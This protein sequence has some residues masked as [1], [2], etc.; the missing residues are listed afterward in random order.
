MWEVVICGEETFDT[1]RVFIA[2]LSVEPESRWR[3]AG[4]ELD[5]MSPG[6]HE[7]VMMD[8]DV[9]HPA[10]RIENLAHGAGQ[11]HPP[12]VGAGSCERIECGRFHSSMPA[13]VQLS[14][15]IDVRQA[16]QGD[17]LAATPSAYI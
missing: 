10:I 3:F 14:A 11:Q 5:V 9:V 16:V 12:A 15:T 1:M 2:C 6:T 13:E 8:F 7:V 17:P 4:S